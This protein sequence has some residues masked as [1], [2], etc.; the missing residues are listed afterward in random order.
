MKIKT[1]DSQIIR[2]ILGKNKF[3]MLN[4]DMIKKLGLN[5]TLLLT[6]LLDKFEYFSSKDENILNRG[7]VFYRIDIEETVGLTAHLQRKAEMKLK[8]LDILTVE[9]KFENKL[10][11]NIYKVNLEKLVQAI[12]DTPSKS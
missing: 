1:I 9:M 2:E 11:Y 6:Y 4:L 8:S 7:M 3:L 5:E 10:T 12:Y